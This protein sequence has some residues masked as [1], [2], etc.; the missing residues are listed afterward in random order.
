MKL[1]LG[2]FFLIA[3]ASGIL[4]ATTIEATC[5]KCT[6]IEAARAKE[7]AE[8]PQPVPYYD[9]EVHK[10]NKETSTI[11]PKTDLSIGK[12]L[13]LNTEIKKKITPPSENS[14]P[15]YLTVAPLSI[16]EQTQSPFS[17]TLDQYSALRTGFITKNFLDTLTGPYT[18]FI[19]SNE[20][21]AKMPEKM[22]AN[23]TSHEDREILSTLVGNHIVG[24][25]ILKQSFSD[26]DSLTFKTISGKL[27]TLSVNNGLLFVEKSQILSIEPAGKD[28]VIYVIDRVIY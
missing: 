16:Y 14:V 21:I 24:T 19:P 15:E 18:L 6:K 12:E 2:K 13:S 28:G 23:L 1:F 17:T 25:K 5:S 22:L 9:I 26:Q 7:Q 3:V 10:Q 11:E 27:L 8:N 4:A 20:A